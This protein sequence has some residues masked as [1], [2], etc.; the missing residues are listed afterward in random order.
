MAEL[1]RWKDGWGTTYPVEA[2]RIHARA[3]RLA[4]L[5]NPRHPLYPHAVAQLDSCVFGPGPHFHDLAY[6]FVAAYLPGL[7]G[8]GER[9]PRVEHD[10]H[11]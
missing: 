2:A 6:A 4:R 10:A 3:T 5:A 8:E 1:G 9:F 11:V 7:G